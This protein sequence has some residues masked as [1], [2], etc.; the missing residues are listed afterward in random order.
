[1]S[2]TV[3]Q[4]IISCKFLAD[5]LQSWK[6]ATCTHVCFVPFVTLELAVY[7]GFMKPTW[8]AIKGKIF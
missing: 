2:I 7:K 3:E 4:V 1:M 6:R 8:E 5:K